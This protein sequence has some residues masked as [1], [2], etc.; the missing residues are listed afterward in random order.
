MNLSRILL[1]ALCLVVGCKT[2]SVDQVGPLPT[3][4]HL[5]ATHQWIRPAGQSVEFGGRPVDLV[6]SPDGRALY[7]KDNRGLVVLDAQN[8]QVRQE[9]KF[10]AGG[11][12]VHGIVVTRD[13]SRIYA[14]TAQNLLW[15][16]KV[17]S[18][19]KIELGQKLTLAGPGGEGNPA[20]G[21]L[22]LSSD[23][24][25]A[26]VCLSRNNS[27]GI[28]DL[29]SGKLLNQIPVGV[30]PY[31]VVLFPAEKGPSNWGAGIRA[32]RKNAK[33][34]GTDTLVDE[35]GVAASGTVSVVD[36][37][38]ERNCAIVTGCILRSAE[39]RPALAPRVNANSTPSASLIPRVESGGNHSRASGPDAASAGAQ[40]AFVESRRPH[41]VGRQR[42][43]QRGGLGFIVAI[44]RR[45]KPRERIHPHRLVSRRLDQ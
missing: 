5:T 29:E 37:D 21:G 20:P 26:Y 33:S 39:R 15:E 45:H 42:W 2:E 41:A 32:R 17:T 23:E 14:T 44:T 30:A 25:T 11:S 3:G 38:Q 16:A 6:L 1:P 8:W 19:G 12:S 27:L 24:K 9:L 43:Q 28:V 35:R 10:A 36:L 13:G 18:D 40:R 7:V 4:G 34:S 22:T 31:D